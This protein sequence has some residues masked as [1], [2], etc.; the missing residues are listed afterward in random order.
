MVILLL[1]CAFDYELRI[2][3]YVIGKVNRKGVSCEGLAKGDAV[4]YGGKLNVSFDE[5][6]IYFILKRVYLEAYMMPG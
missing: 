1:L 3:C 4:D 2:G 5:A 6:I